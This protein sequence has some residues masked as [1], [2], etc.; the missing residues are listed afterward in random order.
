VSDGWAR[1]VPPDAFVACFAHAAI[2]PGGAVEGDP[3]IARA[4]SVLD[5][6]ARRIGRDYLGRIDLFDPPPP[7]IVPRAAAPLLPLDLPA[8][9]PLPRAP[10]RRAVRLSA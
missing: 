2:G 6:A 8:G 10:R 3:D 4:S 1:R 5:W 9:P 7:A